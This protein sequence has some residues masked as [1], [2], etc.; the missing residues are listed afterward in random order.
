M[1]NCSAR[2]RLCTSIYPTHIEKT[3][4]TELCPI[5]KE[6]VYDSQGG[7]YGHLRQ[8]HDISR[9][10]VKLTYFIKSQEIEMDNTDL[11][12]SKNTDPSN[13]SLEVS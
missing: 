13:K 11:D 5:C 9:K 7:W 4:N 8:K 12:S 2:K 6:K 10:T 1:A 3:L